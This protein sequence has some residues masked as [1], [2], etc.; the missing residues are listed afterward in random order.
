MTTNFE[1]YDSA[2]L[3]QQVWRL[4][5]PKTRS[6]VQKK[7]R[8]AIYQVCLGLEIKRRFQRPV[9]LRYIDTK[10]ADDEKSSAPEQTGWDRTTFRI[11]HIPDDLDL[12]KA[13]AVGRPPSDTRRLFC[14][15]FVL[16]R[17]MGAMQQIHSGGYRYNLV[18]RQDI[19]F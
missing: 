14:L 6:F 1:S 5:R 9:D 11:K 16:L 15:K 17:L 12:Q 4:A 8:E 7:T 10:T 13:F 18:S 2:V 19:I 3:S